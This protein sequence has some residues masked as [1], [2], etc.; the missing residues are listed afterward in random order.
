MA[1]VSRK[2]KG[3]SVQYKD[4]IEQMYE[5]GLYIRLSSED[6]ANEG[7]NKL[8]NQEQVIRNFVKEKPDIH[9]SKV[10]CDNGCTGTNFSRLAFEELL[11]DIKERK[12]NCIIVKDLSRLGR[13]HIEVEQY[14]QI[15]F[16]FLKT[17]FI[18]VNDGFDTLHSDGDITVSLKNIVNAA[19]AKDI[20]RKISSTKQA[21]RNKGLFTGNLPPYGYKKSKEDTHKLMIDEEAGEVVREIF[22][23]KLQR[24]T[25]TEI[26]GFL[27]EKGEFC[28]TKYWYQKGLVHQEKFANGI[29][30]A[31]TIKTILQNQMYVGDMVQGKRIRCLADGIPKAKNMKRE[32]YVVVKDTHEALIER[33]VFEKV[34]LNC[35]EEIE[36]NRQKRNKYKDIVSSEDLLGHLISSS[37]GQKMYRSRNIYENQRVTYSYVTSKN[38]KPDGS[39]YPFFYISEDSVLRGLKR[40]IYVQIELLFT[41]SGLINEQVIRKEITAASE[42]RKVKKERLN[43]E[44][45]NYTKCLARIYKDM[46]MGTITPIEYKELKSRYTQKREAAI[47]EINNLQ[48]RN[49]PKKSMQSYLRKYQGLFQQFIEKEELTKELIETLVKDITVIGKK[50]IKVTFLFENEIQ[51]SYEEIVEVKSNA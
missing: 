35:R 17:R 32:K 41:I 27:N 7:N 15:I 10:Y 40:A 2:N 11:Q 9:V 34:Q 6:D 13:N 24:K 18:A 23:F 42:E 1:R 20:S 12:I 49:S 37:D 38:R 50:R 43:I 36:Q 45:N 29:W 21:Q 39:D 31:Q 19:Y 22:N 26:A 51:K 8:E 47:K 28:P 14:I 5:A 33:K 3:I 25:N 44:I 16:P 4:P 48:H 46:S 30:V